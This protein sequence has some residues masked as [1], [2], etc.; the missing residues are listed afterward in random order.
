MCDV[1]RP[2]SRPVK[3]NAE[4]EKQKKKGEGNGNKQ[5]AAALSCGARSEVDAGLQEAT[6]IS[7][8]TSCMDEEEKKNEK[9]KGAT[10]LRA[11]DRR[12]LPAR[13]K[14]YLRLSGKWNLQPLNL[15]FLC[16]P[17]ARRVHAASRKKANRH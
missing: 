10:L 14:Q 17:G 6:V 7:P 2:V 15:Y 8:N 5:A 9:H 4:E 12:M 11:G 13:H 16:H 1:F 3:E